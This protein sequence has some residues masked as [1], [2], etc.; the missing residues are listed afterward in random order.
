VKNQNLPLTS[1]LSPV[2][3]EAD[4]SFAHVDRTA[5]ERSGSPLFF[6]RGEGEGEE[7]KPF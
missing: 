5:L 6:P 2:R 3:G 7:F 1:V 4:G